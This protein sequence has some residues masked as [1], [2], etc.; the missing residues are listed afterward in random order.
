MR[1]LLITQRAAQDAGQTKQRSVTASQAMG[2]AV[3]ADQFALDAKRGRV[4]GDEI[5]SLNVVP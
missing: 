4:E 3:G 5:V 2:S 1:G